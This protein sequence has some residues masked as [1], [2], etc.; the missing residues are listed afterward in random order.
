[1]FEEPFDESGKV[2]SARGNALCAEKTY[3]ARR[4]YAL[5]GEISVCAEKIRLAHEKYGLRGENML[6]A[7]GICWAQGKIGLPVP[8]RKNP[9]SKSETR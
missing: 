6:C 3:I 8:E 1:M 5:R 2:R 7:A 9:F 4:K